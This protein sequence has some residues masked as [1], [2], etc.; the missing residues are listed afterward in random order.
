MINL[1]II[2]IFNIG[3]TK[4]QIPFKISNFFIN[5]LKEKIKIYSLLNIIKIKFKIIKKINNKIKNNHF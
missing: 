4:N 1:K 2:I 5:Y 3:R